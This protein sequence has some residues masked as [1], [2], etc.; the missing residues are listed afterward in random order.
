MIAFCRDAI[1]FS[2]DFLRR[3]LPQ[4]VLKGTAINPEGVIKEL[5]EGE[6]YKS[7]GQVINYNDAKSL[8]GDNVVLI[9]P[10]T[11]LWNFIWEL[12][13][14]SIQFLNST[15]NAAKLFET[16]KSS[17]TIQ[18]MI[19]GLLGTPSPPPPPRLPASPPSPPAS[20]PSSPPS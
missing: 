15:P 3:W 16:E 10:N 6:R 2:K 5:V 1:D 9:D 14:R 19:V 18:V 11:D 17:T 13:L 7:H 12:Y 20:P 4:G 8:L